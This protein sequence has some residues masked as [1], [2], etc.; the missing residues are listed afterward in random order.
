MD[1]LTASR[2]IRF[3]ASSMLTPVVKK[4]HFSRKIARNA[5]MVWLRYARVERACDWS[6]PQH[7]FR[8]RWSFSI[9]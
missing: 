1:L 7:S 2:T 3:F 6:T 9:A 4:C 8:S 5:I